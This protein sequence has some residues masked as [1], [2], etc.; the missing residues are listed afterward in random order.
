MREHRRELARNSRLRKELCWPAR[1]SMAR[2]SVCDELSRAGQAR[3]VWLIRFI[4]FI[5]FIW[6]IRLVWFNQINKT[7]QTNQM[8]QIDWRTF[9]PP[10][11]GARGVSCKTP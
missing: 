6:F 9:Q 3:S 11:R 10:V 1:I 7:N 4:L 2:T 8:N 5:W